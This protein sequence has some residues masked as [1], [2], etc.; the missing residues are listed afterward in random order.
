LTENN[1]YAIL[2]GE[3][4]GSFISVL[5]QH[6]ED[7][8]CLQVNVAKSVRDVVAQSASTTGEKSSVRFET[9]KTVM[10]KQR[11]RLP[12]DHSDLAVQRKLLERGG[13]LLG[14]VAHARVDLD[15]SSRL[16]GEN[17]LLA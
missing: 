15:S 13:E 5:F 4:G 11:F 9:L 14:N 2:D 16:V 3:L 1:R 7:D 12:S 17:L 8:Q 6:V 10:V